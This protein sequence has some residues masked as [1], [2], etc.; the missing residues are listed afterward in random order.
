MIGA[1]KCDLDSGTCMVGGWP[2]RDP[3]V[4]VQGANPLEVRIFSVCEAL[5]MLQRETNFGQIFTPIS[6]PPPPPHV[7][8][9]L[10]GFTLISRMIKFGLSGAEFSPRAER[11]APCLTFDLQPWT[12]IPAYP[13]SSS[14]PKVKVVSNGSNRRAQ[15]HKRTDG[16]MLPSALSPCFA[17]AK[18]LK[19]IGVPQIL[20]DSELRSKLNQKTAYA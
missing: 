8:I 9:F 11:L 2:Y 18:R 19:K 5:T 12:T 15:T 7:D 6:P 1:E 4:G 14:I 16:W 13:R 3:C 17:K 20:A 10:N